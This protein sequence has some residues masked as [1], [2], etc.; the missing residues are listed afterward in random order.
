VTSPV[1][2]EFDFYGAEVK[3]DEAILPLTTS[4]WHH[5]Y[6][7]KHKDNFAVYLS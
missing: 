7:I 4:S 2:E 3:N 1:S 5:A 6:S